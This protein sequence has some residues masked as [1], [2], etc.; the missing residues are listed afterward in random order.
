MIGRLCL[1]LLLFAG[2]SA[3]SD[4]RDA[5]ALLLLAALSRRCE[6]PC[7]DLEIAFPSIPPIIPP[8]IEP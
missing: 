7:V 6:F 8:E 2:C 4:D 5:E 3:P 1:A